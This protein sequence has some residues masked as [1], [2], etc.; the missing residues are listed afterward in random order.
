MTL[1]EEPRFLKRGAK[2]EVP[3]GT[4][5]FDLGDPCSDGDVFFLLSGRV[6]VRST[7]RD[8]G[9]A[10]ST[11]GPGEVCGAAEPYAGVRHRQH[12][13]RALQDCVVYRWNRKSFDDAMGIYQE[14]AT[15]VIRTLSQRLRELNRA[16]GT[17]R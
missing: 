16:R 13:A 9:I 11:L 1:G 5:L 17:A 8:P 3:A 15:Q 12:Q 10:R 6:E 2:E 4:L 7:A 14:L